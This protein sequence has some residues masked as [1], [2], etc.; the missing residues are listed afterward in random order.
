MANKHPL[1]IFKKKQ[2]VTQYY[3]TR[4]TTTTTQTNQL[5]TL[6]NPKHQKYKNYTKG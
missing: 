2:E 5:T 3:S 1:K 4:K 6:Q